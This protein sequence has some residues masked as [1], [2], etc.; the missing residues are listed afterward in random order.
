MLV[1]EEFPFID[2]PERRSG[3]SWEVDPVTGH[4]T[5]LT[6]MGRFSHEQQA[7]GSDGAWYLTDDRGDFRFLYRFV[8][9]SRFNLVNGRLYGLTFDRPAATAA[10]SDRWTPG[11]ARRHGGP[12]L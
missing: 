3:W 4:A 6:G 1:N 5:R 7:L 2:D 11:P 10:G 8:P 9:N 12:W